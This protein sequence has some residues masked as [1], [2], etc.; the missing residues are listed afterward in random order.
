[1]RHANTAIGF[2]R[3]AITVPYYIRVLNSKRYWDTDEHSKFPWLSNNEL[4]SDALLNVKTQG[5][6]LSIYI[7]DDDGNDLDIILCAHASTRD[8]INPIDFAVIPD[9]I[10]SE[11]GLETYDTQGQTLVSHVNDLHQDLVHISADKLVNMIKS[12][13]TYGCIC[14]LTPAK[15]KKLMKLYVDDGTIKI[16]QLKPSVQSKLSS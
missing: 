2:T 11:I 7:L 4:P 12:T 1:M 6:S 9:N 13:I 16:E 8:H 3:G 15:V 10:L 14:R 5:N